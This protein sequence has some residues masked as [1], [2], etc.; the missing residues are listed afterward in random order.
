MPTNP[1]LLGTLCGGISE[2]LAILVVALVVRYIH[3]KTKQQIQQHQIP[4]GHN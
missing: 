2:N 1:F 3:V 4:L